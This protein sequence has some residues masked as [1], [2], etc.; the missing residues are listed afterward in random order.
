MVWTC[1]TYGNMR[2]A[3]TIVDGK[4]WRKVQGFLIFRKS[5]LWI[6]ILIATGSHGLTPAWRW[7]RFEGNVKTNII[8]HIVIVWTVDA[9]AGSCDD[10]DKAR[11]RSISWATIRFSGRIS[12]L[13]NQFNRLVLLVSCCFRCGLTF[14]LHASQKS[15]MGCLTTRLFTLCNKH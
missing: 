1:S 8:E 5:R 14:R 3:Y 11:N 10:G 2:Y 4:S 12:S 6:V 13:R 7:L 9:V 15:R